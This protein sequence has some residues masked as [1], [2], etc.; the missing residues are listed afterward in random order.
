M[1]VFKT[2]KGFYDYELTDIVSYN[3]K[4]W[5]EYGLLELGAYTK[6]GFNTPTSGYTILKRTYDDRYGNNR[7]FEGMG[8]SWVWE[9]GIQGIDNPYATF[10]V[11]GVY[12]DDVF[13]PTSG[14]NPAYIVD[15]RNGRIIFQNAVAED[16][17]VKCE[18]VFR[19]IGVYLTD[20]PQWKTVIKEY[21]QNLV[22]LEDLSPSGM[23]SILK[24]NRVWLPSVFINTLN[25]TNEALQLGGGHL[26]TCTIGINILS[27]YPFA[28]RKLA[29]V[30]ISQKDQ[31]FKLFDIN[32]VE[33]QQRYNGTVPSGMLT[34]PELVSSKTN[35]Y[36]WAFGHLANAYGGVSDTTTN[37]YRA[38]VTYFM[39]VERHLSTY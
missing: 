32:K 26:A 9:E 16:T 3:I 7:V 12:V 5:M 23:A 14:I 2:N 22:D 36:F 33:A 27:E 6:V 10:A 30:L 19:D 28:C 4:T 1:P 11:S 34:Y 39:D 21:E 20:S 38:E 35:G 15:Y 17:E 13:C 31:T 25:T 37:V 24:E 29:D 8:P 18:Y